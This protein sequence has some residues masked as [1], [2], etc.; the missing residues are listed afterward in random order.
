[1]SFLNKLLTYF[2]INEDEYFELNKKVNEGDILFYKTINDIEIAKNLILETINNKKKILICGNCDIDGILSIS[3][4]INTFKILNFKPDYY[5]II[6][7]DFNVLINEKYSL[8][9]FIGNVIKKINKNL[10]NNTNIIVINNKKNNN[11]PLKCN[12]YLKYKN[13]EMNLTTNNSIISFY[14]SYALLNKINTYFISL[15]AISIIANML[16]IKKNENRNIV[17]LAIKYL[18]KYKFYKFNLISG[19]IKYDE[20]IIKLKIIPKINAVIKIDQKKIDTLIDYFTSDNYCELIKIRDYLIDI[21]EKKKKIITDTIDELKI[22]EDK[23]YIF[24]EINIFY[25][26]IGLAANRLLNIF[27]KPICIFTKK[28]IDIIY[29]SIR[30][31]NNFNIDFLFEKIK[32]ICITIYLR[33]FAIDITLKNSDIEILEKEFINYVNKQFITNKY[34]EINLNEINFENYH[35]IKTLSPFGENWEEPIFILKNINTNNFKKINNKI[36]LMNI[37]DKIRIIKFNFKDDILSDNINLIGKI[38][39]LRFKN[40]EIIN[41]IIE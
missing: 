34:I 40:K 28:D 15:T 4:I 22:D 16:S 9:I 10:N 29:C 33:K 3:I 27:N 30:I 32:K 19:E 36:L 12:A 14:L 25:N 8:I 20:N 26:L 37:N 39:M 41:F 1:M 2:N 18:N 31:K 11:F 24:M 5:L 17:K 21:N 13:E 7:D 6:Y 35:L 38:K 23:K